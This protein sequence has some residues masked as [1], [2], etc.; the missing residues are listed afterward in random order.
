MRK[1]FFRKRGSCVRLRTLC[2]LPLI[3]IPGVIWY[4]TAV[5]TFIHTTHKPVNK[6]GKQ[7]FSVPDQKTR[8]VGW[9]QT[10]LCS[11]YGYEGSLT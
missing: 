10:T 4:L 9:R 8:C 7:L 11:P 3:L 2:L 5:S 1:P 6:S